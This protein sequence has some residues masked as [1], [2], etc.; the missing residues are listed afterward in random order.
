MNTDSDGAKEGALGLPKAK[1]S[2]QRR[3][4]RRS[5]HGGREK[6]KK[7]VWHRAVGEQQTLSSACFHCP[8]C[9]ET[10]RKAIQG[11]CLSNFSFSP[12]LLRNCPFPP[13]LK[14]GVIMRGIG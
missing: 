4:T 5:S 2:G 3:R 6:N 12:S 11:I 1:S 7:G 10:Q 8:K 9:K 14:T 13:P